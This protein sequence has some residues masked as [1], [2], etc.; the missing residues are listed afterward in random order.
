MMVMRYCSM[1]CNKLKGLNAPPTS[2]IVARTIMGVST[3]TT[4]AFT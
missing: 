2:T 1:R 3:D 4:C